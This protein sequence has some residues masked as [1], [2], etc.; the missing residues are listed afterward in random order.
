MSSTP[1]F[2]TQ[3]F[4]GNDEVV[5][6]RNMDDDF[7]PHHQEG[8]NYFDQKLIVADDHLLTSGTTDKE[9]LKKVKCSS[10]LLI[11]H[12]NHNWFGRILFIGPYSDSIF[13]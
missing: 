8:V 6:L 12:L 5:E 4:E 10:I 9:K 7:E 3:N 13:P 1:N 11:V 2:I